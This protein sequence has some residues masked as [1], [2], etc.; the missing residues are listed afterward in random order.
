MDVKGTLGGCY[1]IKKSGQPATCP[2]IFAIHVF[3][4]IQDLLAGIG[5]GYNTPG[6]NF[7]TIPCLPNSNL[8]MRFL[9]LA[10]FSIVFLPGLFG[11]ETL[12]LFADRKTYQPGDTIRLQC[13]VPEWE[14]TARLGTVN[15]LV[16]DVQH[17]NLWR[18]RYPM[19]EGYYHAEIY[20]PADLPHNR[21]VITAELQPVFFQLWGRQLNREKG[22]SIRYTLQ[23]EDKT[24]IAGL[25]PLNGEGAFRM[26]RHIF[27]GRAILYFSPQKP[28]KINNQTDVSI[29]APL[30]SPF[31]PIAKATLSLLVGHVADPGSHIP[32]KAD[33]AFLAN[34]GNTLQ[35]VQVTGT[36]RTMLEQFDHENA[37][38]YFKGGRS[39]VFSGL[40]GGFSD[41]NNILDYL[42]GRVAGLNI[43]KNT[44]EMGEY[45]VT[46]RNEPTA[47]FIDEVP[48]DLQAAIN[49]PPF[50]IAMV[51]V[52]PPPFMGIVLGAG[53][54][55]IAI[56]SK[57]ASTGRYKKAR[58]RFVVQ[59]F[60][61]GFTTLKVLFPS[62]P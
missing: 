23:L 49:F 50:E 60:S 14:G 4:A 31:T 24:I 47:F 10:F 44:E 6:C 33:S 7:A 25:L 20:L 39:Q 56:Y 21:Y 9:V 17:N 19:V 59:G 16:E 42:N 29:S 52:F 30:D 28:S 41:F 53:G 35:T 1:E 22:D 32:Y 40:D 45:L 62:K 12:R 51:K 11:Q 26:P 27:S 46:W 8:L 34:Q 2:G 54:G 36:R 37:S 61:P 38:G 55:A 18:L 15:L 5:N 58:N 48:V 43:Q 13:A 3:F 57:K